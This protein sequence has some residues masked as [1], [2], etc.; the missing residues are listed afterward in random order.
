MLD[1][2]CAEQARHCPRYIIKFTHLPITTKWPNQ[3]QQFQTIHL[4]SVLPC[5]PT[6]P[7]YS[8]GFRRCSTRSSHFSV[9]N[10]TDISDLEEWFIDDIMSL[11]LALS[12]DNHNWLDD[13]LVFSTTC[14]HLLYHVSLVRSTISAKERYR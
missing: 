12:T 10:L 13:V 6:Q 2:S 8:N 11:S 9:Q 5:W 14:T 3:R 1:S 4:R 7:M